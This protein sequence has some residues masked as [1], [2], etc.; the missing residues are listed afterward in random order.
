[1]ILDNLPVMRIA[2]QNGINIQWTGF[3]VGYTP[4][5]SNDD[6]IINHLKFKVLVHEYEGSAVQITGTGE[7]GMGVISE[8]DKKASEN[9]APQAPTHIWLISITPMSGPKLRIIAA[10]GA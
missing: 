10:S 3:L 7:E 2:K 1:M 5:N 8:A 6:Y 4:R 9:I